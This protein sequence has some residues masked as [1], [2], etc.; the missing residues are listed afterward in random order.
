MPL[1]LRLM[2]RII[3]ENRQG[4]KVMA[5]CSLA[6]LSRSLTITFRLDQGIQDILKGWNGGSIFEMRD[7][8]IEIGSSTMKATVQPGPLKGR[9]NLIHL[10]GVPLSALV[11]GVR[12]R[13]RRLIRS[14][15]GRMAGG[16]AGGPV[17]SVPRR[18]LRPG[19]SPTDRE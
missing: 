16:A 17:P 6:P 19:A 18:G 12:V 13:G 10:L 4:R 8:A 1:T 5:G 11:F 14:R 2:W 9:R 7:P 15:E 3:P